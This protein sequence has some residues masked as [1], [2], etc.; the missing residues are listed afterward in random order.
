MR[1]N[2][3]LWAALECAASLVLCIPL[4]SCEGSAGT[5]DDA[6][7]FSLPWPPPAGD[8]VKAVS[9]TLVV[10]G[11]D[12]LTG[13]GDISIVGETAHISGAS[14]YSLAYYTISGLSAT[15]ECRAV[16]IA[17]SSAHTV[18]GGATQM[19]IGLAHY[20]S[21]RWLWYNNIDTTW[22][23]EFAA[24]EEY[25]SSGHGFSDG[26]LSIVVAVVGPGDCVVEALTYTIDKSVVGVPQHPW[27][28]SGWPSID[29]C[30]DEVPDALGY[31]FYRDTDPG[32]SSPVKLNNTL[33]PLSWYSDS[34]LP[35]LMYYYRVTSVLYGESAP[36]EIVE[37][38][39]AEIGFVAPQNP[40]FVSNTES[41]F[42]VGW[43]WEGEAP[44]GGFTLYL[45]ETLDFKIDANTYF[46]SIPGFTRKSTFQNLEQGVVYYWRICARTTSGLRGPM[47]DDQPGQ[48]S[49]SWT[50]GPA[51][52][53]GPGYKPSSATVAG[54]DLALAYFD[55]AG[56]S[57]VVSMRDGGTWT[58]EETG[59]DN[60]YNEGGFSSYVSLAY[61]GGRLM[62]AAYSPGSTDL[63]GSVRTDGVWNTE[64]IDA[65]FAHGIGVPN[66]GMMC[67]AAASDTEFAV[68]YVAYTSCEYIATRPIEGGSGW[69]LKLLEVLGSASAH[70]S[71]QFRDGDLYVMY[72]RLLSG[73]L[74]FGSRSGGYAMSDVTSAGSNRGTFND[75]EWVFDNWMT[76]AYDPGEY[77]L[78]AISGDGTTWDA[79]L[80][81]AGT[82]S[83][84]AGQSA[85]MAPYSGGAY[86]IYYVQNPN[87]W[88]LG[89]YDGT[90]WKFYRLLVGGVKFDG[91]PD[92]LTLDDSP[93]IVFRDGVSQQY[94]CAKG[95]PPAP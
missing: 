1:L 37:A 9:E 91:A 67:V 51:E 28:R 12:Y 88:R 18:P 36:S 14:H 41:S 64:P 58:A 24:P 61:G 45:A 52:S 17:T 78:Y 2:A 11:K 15:N 7:G 77:S 65:D 50:W 20:G 94:Q 22:S 55:T 26:T 48:C 68:L 82:S 6:A 46:K 49:G 23:M 76:P 80:V 47:T 90:N 39:S 54:D 83:S 16:S 71:L 59:L 72:Y 29:V 8:G 44:Q 35:G 74:V 75:L 32:F 42:T 69:S 85:R 43:D 56:P 89:V 5:P 66:Q 84:P 92:I 38:W 40:H 93:Y 87:S 60:G 73:D 19:F 57:V 25:R 27:A 13:S 10:P 62:C 3:L 34:P 4:C 70:H 33:W 53:I 81:A 21:S 79:S 30:C 63:F 31:N 95:T 86:V